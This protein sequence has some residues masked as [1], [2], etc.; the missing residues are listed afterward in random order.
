M[1]RAEF[2]P[3]LD[4]PP[5]TLTDVQ[6]PARFAYLLSLRFAGKPSGTSV[7]FGPFYP[8]RMRAAHRRLQGVHVERL[9][10]DVFIPRYDKPFTLFY[11]NPPN[12]SH[13]TDHSVRALTVDPP[14]GARLPIR[15]ER[16]AGVWYAGAGL[17]GERPL[18]TW[19]AGRIALLVPHPDEA[20]MTAV[21]FAADGKRKAGS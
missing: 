13:E 16:N 8:N 14:R 12:W 19:R 5:A 6:R 21:H 2:N 3:L 20:E 10:W 1:A 7:K 4:V 17:L 18:A 15:P 11:I 9:D